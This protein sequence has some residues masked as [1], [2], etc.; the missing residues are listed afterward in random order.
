MWLDDLGWPWPKH[1]CMDRQMQSTKWM[2]YIRR[3]VSHRK[4][5]DLVLGIIVRAKWMPET[6]EGPCR[7]VLAIDGEGGRVCVATT[8][9]N[10][11]DYLLGRVAVADLTKQTLLTSNME[12]RPILNFP[13][14][15]T[16]LGLKRGWAYRK[17][18]PSI[19]K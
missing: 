18:K 4:S 10:T 14:N 19:N 7:I 11:A 1:A 3:R 15:V 13:T 12:E 16:E 9:L 17:R 5:H 8:G 2:P 6:P